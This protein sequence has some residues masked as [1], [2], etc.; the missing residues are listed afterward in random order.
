MNIGER[1]DERNSKCTL[2]MGTSLKFT[3]PGQWVSM[4]RRNEGS[5]QNGE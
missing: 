2:R 5:G 1:A 4:K 3:S